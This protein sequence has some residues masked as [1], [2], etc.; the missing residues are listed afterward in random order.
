S[1]VASDVSTENFYWGSRLIGALADPWYPFTIQMVDRYQGA[2]AN[3]G[4]RI[5]SEYDKKMIEAKK[6][7]LLD[8]ANEKL[9]EMAKKET[10]SALNNLVL[11]AS[12]HMRNNFNRA[13]N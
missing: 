12:K 10:T 8:E 9:C 5:I 4:H 2:M 3:G 7:D 6:F 13:D 11:E 1:E